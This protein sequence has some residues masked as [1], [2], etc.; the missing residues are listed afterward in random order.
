MIT[1][2]KLIVILALF[3]ISLVLIV[4]GVFI[5]A[6]TLNSGNFVY[7]RISARSILS[8]T[9]NRR[10][11]IRDKIIC[12]GK[13]IKANTDTNNARAN[14]L[15]KAQWCFKYGLLLIGVLSLILAAVTFYL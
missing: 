8:D 7:H 10:E 4:M 13:F 1:R 15:I 2:Q 11:F 5:A 3:V 9:G 6:K 14:I 12:I